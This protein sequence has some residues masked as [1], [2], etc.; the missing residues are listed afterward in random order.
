MVQALLSQVEPARLSANNPG[1]LALSPDA[2][3]ASENE[4]STSQYARDTPPNYLGRA[5]CL[6]G[7]R[8]G[9]A[10]HRRGLKPSIRTHGA[11]DHTQAQIA[12]AQRVLTQASAS[13]CVAAAF[14]LPEC[15]PYADILVSLAG[16]EALRWEPP[17][18]RPPSAPVNLRRKLCQD[19]R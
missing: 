19:H 6:D 12:A 4:L 8:Q 11:E 5:T 17:A 18:T 2:C 3:I 14:P 13:H 1:E 7:N 10:T 9:C 16:R 15:V